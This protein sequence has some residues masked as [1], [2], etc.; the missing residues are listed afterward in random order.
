MGKKALTRDEL[1]LVKL[2]I[3]SNENNDEDFEYDVN[4]IASRA[5]ITPKSAEN[6]VNMLAQT[7]FIKKLPEGRVCITSHGEKLAALLLAGLG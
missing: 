7:N 3:A 5:G 2:Y 6:V 1:F 4:E